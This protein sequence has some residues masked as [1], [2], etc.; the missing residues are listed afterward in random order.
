MVLR[1][2]YWTKLSAMSF[3]LVGTKYYLWVYISYTNI[4]SAILSAIH[5]IK[6]AKIRVFTDPYSRMFY[7]VMNPL[8]AQILECVGRNFKHKFLHAFLCVLTQGKTHRKFEICVRGNL[9]VGATF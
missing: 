1:L 5:C 9:S 6:Y 3:L 2:V 7:A 4:S 8:N